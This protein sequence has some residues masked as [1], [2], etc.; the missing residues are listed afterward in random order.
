MNILE[1]ALAKILLSRKLEWFSEDHARVV[2][3]CCEHDLFSWKEAGEETN[4]NQKQIKEIIFD[5]SRHGIEVIPMQG[6][7]EALNQL[8]EL[9]DELEQITSVIQHD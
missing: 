3:Y 2:K 8:V 9:A 6:S 1:A 4:L 7:L 5:L